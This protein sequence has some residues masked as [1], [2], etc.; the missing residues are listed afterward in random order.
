MVKKTL[1]TF[2]ASIINYFHNNYNIDVEIGSPYLISDLN[3]L[4]GDFT[5]VIQISG[6]YSGSCYFSTPKD[7]LKHLIT[8]LEINGIDIENEEVLC[9]I[10]GEIANTL[11]GNARSVLGEN[12]IISIPTVYRGKSSLEAIT[13]D[14]KTDERTY[15]IPV[16]WQSQKAFLGINLTH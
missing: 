3:E 7:L 11:S 12:F 8:S 4:R 6:K 14:E 5:G 9:D 13:S 2:T 16:N 1:D 10:T 15:A